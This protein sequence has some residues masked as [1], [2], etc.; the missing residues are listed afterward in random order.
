MATNFWK[1]LLIACL[2]AGKLSAQE[3]GTGCVLDADLYKKVP[4]SVA[5]GDYDDLPKA[6]S[7]RMYA[8]TPQNQGSYGT[9][10]GW[11]TAYAAHTIQIAH[12]QNWTNTKLIT[13]N[14]FSP[15]FVYESAKPSSDIHCQ[16]GTSLYNGLE[17]LKDLGAVKVFDYPNKCG[18]SVS[19]TLERK[20]KQ[21][22]IKDYNRLFDRDE[23]DK[24]PFVKKALPKTAL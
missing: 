11:A 8:P 1:G 5:R 2:W 23:K 10:V 24:L 4:L 20:A 7:L 15:F 14:A 17:I 3:Y 19:K 16:E 21:F 9:C 18:Q 12:K 22:K 13:D 6:H